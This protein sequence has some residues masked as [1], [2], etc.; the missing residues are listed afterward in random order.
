[1]GW[2]SKICGESP[3]VK[4]SA[5]DSCNC[6]CTTNCCLPFLKRKKTDECTHHV[7]RRIFKESFEEERSFYG[8]LGFN[9]SRKEK[10]ERLLQP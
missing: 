4:I 6:Q 8:R 1:M 10:K 7:A 2:L 9:A 3:R 5:Q